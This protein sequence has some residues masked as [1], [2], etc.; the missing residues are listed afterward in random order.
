MAKGYTLQQKCLNKWIGSSPRKTIL[1][2]S[3][4]YTDPWRPKKTTPRVIAGK[5][6]IKTKSH[7]KQ[8]AGVVAGYVSV[9]MHNVALY[10]NFFLF[11][12]CTQ[13]TILIINKYKVLVSSVKRFFYKSDLSTAHGHPRSLILVRNESVYTCYFLLVRHSNLGPILHCFWDIEGFY[14][15][16]TLP[17]FHH[18]FGTRSPMLRLIWAGTLSY[19]AVKLFSKYSNLCE[20]HTWTSQTDRETDGRTDG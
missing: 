19:S 14:V 18:N 15:L 17:L 9:T 5:S 7:Q 1:Q 13:C 2:I 4:L 8:T 20:K 10:F 12:C 6:C 11:L 3:I 16:L